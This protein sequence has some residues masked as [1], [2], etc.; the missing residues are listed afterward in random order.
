M[1]S[2]L[3]RIL[4][5]THTDAD[6]ET[7]RQL[8][9]NDDRETISQLGKYNVNIKEGKDIHI[10]DRIYQQLDEA[11]ITAIVTAIQATNTIHQNTQ[12][13]DAAARDLD[14][15]TTIFQFFFS[16]V[17]F[18]DT[19]QELLRDLDFSGISSESIERAYE[20]SLPPYADDWGLPGNNINQKL[21]SLKQFERL[22][23][24]FD[25]L[26]RSENLTPEVRDRFQEI[27]KQLSA[28][29]PPETTKNKSSP[30]SDGD[31]AIHKSYLI[32]TLTPDDRDRFLLRAW[33]ITDDSEQDISKRFDPLLDPNDKL[34]GK[35]CNLAQ[36]PIELNRF[37]KKALK[38]LRG[39]RYELTIE[40]FLPIDLMYMEIDRWKITDPIADE[41]TLGIKYP[42]RLRSLERLGLD[43]LDTY[44]SQWYQAW[45][46]VRVVLQ[47]DSIHT[48]FEHLQ[49]IENFNWEI[50]RNNLKD[51]I[52]LKVTCTHPR[53]MRKD[54]F[55]AI[56]QATTPVAI[57]IRQDFPHLDRVRAI[58]EIL[59]LQPLCHLCES[60]RQ[61]RATADAQA[62]EH[63]GLHLALLWENPYRLT[64]DVMVELM[65]AG[66]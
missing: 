17:D 27:A 34:P 23:E 59:A 66:Q 19:S 8:L 32:A 62:E 51:K 18:K 50:L 63:L 45:D 9:A 7:L 60:V 58:D 31:R 48:E 29:K 53:S 61:T 24:F 2:Y 44:L 33:L 3:Q 26:V 39:R 28:K 15:S 55:R 20:D 43:Y 46:N 5:G 65:Q 54:L 40:I 1:S 37:L 35:I 16:G 12:G 21:R 52:G 57:W 30:N 42:I 4:D 47:D 13:G 36:V 41:I 25:H 10:G 56:L 22:P 38:Q 14:K 49:I 6:L 11:A 64:P